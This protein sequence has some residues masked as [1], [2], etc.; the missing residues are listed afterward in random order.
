MVEFVEVT[1]IE[2]KAFEA[3]I[4]IYLAAFPPE[5]SQPVPVVTERVRQGLSR[6]YVGYL[7]QEVVSMALLWSLQGTDF[8]LLD[9]LATSPAHQNKSIGAKFLQEMYARLKESGKYF[10]IEV[11]D[12][13]FE[14]NRELKRRRLEFYRRNGARQ[15]KATGYILPPIQNEIATPMRLL[16]MPELPQKELEA[17]TVR[18]LIRQL[19]RELYGRDENDPILN[20]F[21]N[22]IQAPVE[23][24]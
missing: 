1:Q 9:Y 21:V 20:S 6:L 24:V 3:A 18:K 17:E 8:I 16:V 7:G 23:I 19:Y 15:L 10:V 5:E 13:D 22:K 11:E 4:E 14:P 2:D 12:P